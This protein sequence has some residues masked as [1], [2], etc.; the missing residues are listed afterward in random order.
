MINTLKN[1]VSFG[2]ERDDF[3][4]YLVIKA[5]DEG[6][7]VNYQVEMI[8]NNKIP[9]LLPVYVRRKNNETYF[10]YNI[11]SKITLLQFLNRV[12]IRKEE[13]INI[14]LQITEI[15]LTGMN[16]LLYNKCFIL[17][18]NYIYINPATYEVYLLYLPV[19]DDTDV[20]RTLRNFIINLIIYS[21]DIA[22][23][24][25]SDNYIQKIL[26]YVKCETFN[27]SDFNRLLVRLGNGEAE[28]TQQ[29]DE[30]WEANGKDKVNE[31]AK[32]TSCN[33]SRVKQGGFRLTQRNSALTIAAMSQ[34]IIIL[35]V[36]SSRNLLKLLGGDIKTAYI[37][38]GLIIIAI[39][40]LIFKN[41]FE[42]K[43]TERIKGDTGRKSNGIYNMRMRVN[44]VDAGT[45]IDTADY[46]DTV[47]SKDLA[48]NMADSM[49]V[50]GN[51]DNAGD[52]GV[53]GVIDTTSAMDIGAGINTD[54]G[55][56]TVLL[57]VEKEEKPF[58]RYVGDGFIEETVVSKEDFLIGRLQ[59]QVDYVIKNSAVGKIHAQIISR[60]GKYYIKDLN[61]RNGTFIN[62]VKINSNTEYEIKDGDRIAFANSDHIFILR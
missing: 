45:D 44:S 37:A 7:I 41:L 35:L 12:K 13:L 26:N 21:A 52:I 4:S 53:V 19:P 14:L 23:E 42:R 48:D 8:V 61:S 57:A 32:N 50:A 22:D 34:L 3:A 9:G 27:V 39:E 58:L 20:N 49:D 30:L 31:M 25:T 29:E 51:M 10:Y 56:N 2:Y 40:I 16:F 38:V 60:E 59:G 36:L 47:R 15:M 11:T 5:E 54:Y 46:M 24:N 43:K 6:K 62:E 17:Q 1:G 18:E 55:S 28:E 33:K